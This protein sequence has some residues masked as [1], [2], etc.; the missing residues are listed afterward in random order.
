MDYNE[1]LSKIKFDDKGL[2]ACITQDVSTNA[3]LMMAYMNAQSLKLT[4][5][6]GYMT[7]FSRSRQELWK[8][9]GNSGNLQKLVSLKYD[10]DGDALLAIIEQNGVACHTGEYSCFHNLAYGEDFVGGYAIID[11]L[12]SVIKDRKE[13]PK[14]G[15]YTNYLFDK[16]IDKIL[17]KVGEETSEVI[18]AAKNSSYDELR[19]E[20]ADLLYHLFVLLANEGLSPADIM[21]ELAK[22]R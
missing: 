8:K 10:C 12:F 17:K 9:G 14:E 19:Y 21:T 1:L 22:R 5:E 20:T 7:Y 2:V 13:T 15:S 6:S 3:V 4:L 16:G 18:I 11:E